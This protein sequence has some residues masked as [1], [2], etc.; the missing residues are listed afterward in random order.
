MRL[1]AAVAALLLAGC[2]TPGAD[3]EPAGGDR[4][5]MLDL[6]GCVDIAS[7]FQ[8]P[9]DELAPEVPAPL[10]VEPIDPAERVGQRW[11][12]A[13]RCGVEGAGL[14]IDE[15][16]LFFET[17]RVLAPPSPGFEDN[18]TVERGSFVARLGADDARLAD[19]LRAWGHAD[20]Q[21]HEI[22]FQGPDAISHIASA[23]NGPDGPTMSAAAL[24]PVEV[25]IEHHRF[26]LLGDGV[27]GGAFDLVTRP[28]SGELGVAA[29][30][31]ERAGRGGWFSGDEYGYTFTQV[32]RS[33][34]A[35]E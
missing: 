1:L 12:V 8:A 31:G 32:P 15:A 5:D 18:R 7:Y 4:A 25:G 9:V 16:H 13:M 21:L 11:I 23:R 19:V 10:L 26:F 28:G 20:V 14:A 6:R 24:A 27:V 34:L 22:P 3:P 17:I 35:L 29:W 33:A 30:E 2:A